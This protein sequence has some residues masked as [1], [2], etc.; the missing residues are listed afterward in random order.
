MELAIYHPWLKEKGGA[1]KVVLET[2]KR[3]KHNVTIF[4][5]LYD[6]ER[7]FDG[8]EDLQV[9]HIGPDWMGNGLL[10][11]FLMITFGS[12]IKKI[13]ERFDHLLISTAGMA[14]TMVFRNKMEKTCYCHTPLRIALPEFRQLYRKKVRKALRPL[15]KIGIPFYNIV[16]K[17]SWKRFNNIIA[18]SQ[19]TKERII[20]KGLNKAKNIE[21]VHP[22]AEIEN[23]TTGDFENYFFYPSRFHHYKRQELA[24][25]AFQKADLDDFKLVL[26]GSAQ[27]KKYVQK[28]REKAGKNI[29]IKTDVPDQEWRNLYRNCYTVL[30]LAE[31]ED[32]GIIPIEAGSFSKPTL[33]V[34]E[35]GP[36]ESVIEDVT[37]H[38]VE[39]NPEAIAEKIK[40]MAANKEKTMEMGKKAREESKKYS[41]E[42]FTKK[43]DEIIEKT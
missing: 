27:D 26:A 18:N 4:T 19:N 13:P 3:S 31:N 34:N 1:E 14:E 20:S 35:G 41:W 32:W 36:T 42:N 16:E 30:F 6:K 38:L 40:T 29:E 28:L 8:F 24:I 39:P 22:G 17:A 43:I 33:A 11:K 21:I 2:A 7:T 5:F 15:L 23:N 37:G 12:A 9:K 25:E 10:E